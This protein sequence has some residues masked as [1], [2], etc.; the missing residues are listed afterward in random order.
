MHCKASYSMCTLRSAVAL[1]S[2]SRCTCRAVLLDN[3]D[4]MALVLH[5]EP[6]A[7]HLAHRRMLF[8]NQV[9]AEAE[10]ADD[11]PC[12]SQT[13]PG[14]LQAGL[15]SPQA[16][17][18]S[19]AA[20]VLKLLGLNETTAASPAAAT[21]ASAQAAPAAPTAPVPDLLGGLDDEPPAPTAASMLGRQPSVRAALMP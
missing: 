11:T 17:I 6:T 12:L 16:S 18:R 1:L 9:P 2:T 20:R 5:A 7:T 13:Q 10:D 8:A 4:F 19:R 21:A 3:G 14:P 15:S